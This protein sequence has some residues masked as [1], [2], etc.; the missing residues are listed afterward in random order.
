MTVTLLAA[1]GF[2]IGLVAND[3]AAQSLHDVPFRPLVGT[4]SACGASNGLN[5][6]RCST[7]DRWKVRDFVVPVATAGFAIC[8]YWAFGLEWTLLP[9]LGFLLLT[10]ALALTD[11]DAMRIVDR[12]N[13]RGSGLAIGGLGIV[14]IA[15]EQTT[16]FLRGLAGGAAYFGATF[17]LF[18]L[19][20]GNGFGAGDVKLAP[21]LGVF[22]TYLGWEVLGRSVVSTAL[23]GG[24]LALFALAF[25]AAKRDTELPYGPAMILGSWVA[26]ALFGVGS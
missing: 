18:L 5:S 16:E 15:N 24:V 3:L 9:Y 8:L 4:C 2:L 10:T 21:V 20:R 14:S 25:M 22:T 11:I 23:I 7:C 13:L 6:F 12:L 17:V 19:V 26:L 1:A